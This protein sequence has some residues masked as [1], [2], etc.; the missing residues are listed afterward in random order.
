LRG[1]KEP[2]LNRCY[3]LRPPRELRDKILRYLLYQPTGIVP[4]VPDYQQWGGPV[5]WEIYNFKHRAGQKTTAHYCFDDQCDYC[6]I[7]CKVLGITW[8][9]KPNPKQ[10]DIVTR[11]EPHL[12]ESIDRHPGSATHT[13]HVVLPDTTDKETGDR[14]QHYLHRRFDGSLEVVHRKYMTVLPISGTEIL[15]TC[16]Q[17]NL[18]G[19]KILYGENLF[20]FNNIRRGREEGIYCFDPENDLTELASYLPG[21]PREGAAISENQVSVA[22]Q[23][24]F[25]P[26]KQ[27]GLNGKGEE[28]LH[29]DSLLN[30]FRKIGIRNASMLTRLKLEGHFQEQEEQDVRS[31]LDFSDMLRCYLTVMKRV[32]CNIRSLTLH[33]RDAIAEDE[34]AA[35]R[36]EDSV[37]MLVDG[38]PTLQKL[39]LGQYRFNVRPRPVDDWGNT[40]RWSKIVDERDAVDSPAVQE[41]AESILTD[42][43]REA[44][45]YFQAIARELHDLPFL[46]GYESSF[47]PREKAR[48]H[49]ASYAAEN[50]GYMI[51]L[52]PAKGE[53]LFKW[54]GRRYSG[55]QW[56]ATGELVWRRGDW[57]RIAQRKLIWGSL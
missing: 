9:T 18:E 5:P 38:L 27:L 54:M 45:N 3:L 23:K 10:R 4:F 49:R 57:E 22:F 53:R 12:L 47:R 19:S 29:W 24:L 17:L 25:A 46:D 44:E 48:H 6:S 40:V 52:G 43:N 37:A 39:Q 26:Q 20:V 36:A 50:G 55:Y 14:V 35:K 11:G 1:L 16:K 51:Y 32:G 8:T 13:P 31:R 41:S 34:D 15:R 30:V 56:N 33:T 21:I 2:P 42:I 28:I 7:D